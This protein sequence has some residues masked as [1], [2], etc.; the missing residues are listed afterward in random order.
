MSEDRK[1]IF[2]L[3]SL[4]VLSVSSTDIYVSSLPEMT[5]DF[6]ATAKLINMTLSFFVI[7]IAVGT[8]FAGTFS[9][10]YGRRKT[11][12]LANGLYIPIT[13]A[14][15]FSNN[16]L[17]VII[18]RFLQALCVS[19]NIVVAR[20][21]IKDYFSYEEQ[22]NATATMLTGVILSPA[23]APVVG[24]HLSECF[25]WRA[26]FIASAILGIAVFVW[27]YMT[28]E[29]TNK[30]ILRKLPSLG[31]F[32]KG[33]IDLVLSKRLTGYLTVN[34]C[35]YASYFAFVTISSYVYILEFKISPPNY[36]LV[37]IGLAFAYLAGNYLTRF[38]IKIKMCPK[39]VVFIGCWCGFLG[40][41][42]NFIYFFFPHNAAVAISCFTFGAI[43]ARVGI[44][45]N[46]APIQVMVMNDYS[47]KS[48]QA[49]GL[50]YFFMFIYESLAA[51]LV[52]TFH[53]NPAIGLVIVTSLFSFV[54]VP[55]WFYTIKAKRNF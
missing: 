9:D 19:C 44:G 53:K 55:V 46:N 49:I 29:E 50:L 45:I 2:L 23:L 48:G 17:L 3:A 43:L 40:A 14:I 25:G 13:L 54:M 33:Y 28:I 15:A 4:I 21:V 5:I 27:L 22:I 34:S 1:L 10:R 20:Q 26:C 30:N 52:S 41:L 7:G 18:L 16:I 12:L 6:H 35:A 32:I 39:K 42:I 38:F 31:V 36:S 8:L 11:L 37:Y 47:E 51:T 24:A